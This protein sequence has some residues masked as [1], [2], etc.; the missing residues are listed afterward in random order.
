[1]EGPRYAIYFV[2][3]EE[4]ALYRFGSSWLGYDCY[5]GTALSRPPVPGLT[6]E[7]A[8]QLTREPRTYGF[9]G[10]LKAPFHLDLAFG[11]EEL[12]AAIET[13]GAAGRPIPAFEPAVELLE[14]FVAIVPASPCAALDKLAAD[15][16]RYFDRFRAPLSEKDRQRRPASGLIARQRENLEAWGYPYVF[17]DFRFHMTLTGRVPKETRRSV[18][19]ALQ[20]AFAHAYGGKSVPVDRVA[21][22]IQDR[23]GQPFRVLRNVLLKP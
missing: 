1:M 13:V 16:V 9:H 5:S 10:T 14:S 23:E 12:L 2:P 21:L 8:D 15:C 18:L 22:L 4:G 19:D 3:A 6:A 11:E 20:D 7:D 17:E